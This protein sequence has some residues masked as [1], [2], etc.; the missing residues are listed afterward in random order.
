MRSVAA[1]ILQDYMSKSV[2]EIRGHTRLSVAFSSATVLHFAKISAV[3][4][5]K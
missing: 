1:M 5:K 3:Q 2:E 4:F